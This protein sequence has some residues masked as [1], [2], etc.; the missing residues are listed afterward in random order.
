MDVKSW[1]AKGDEIKK[2]VKERKESIQQAFRRETGL[3]L[4]VVKQGSINTNTVNT[5][6]RFF[7]NPELT[8]RLTGLDV[9]LIR[10]MAIILQCISSGEKINTESF[11]CFAVKQQ[12]YM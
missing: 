6:R 11:G 7:G 10:R 4:D 12:I 8:A 9:K 2:K 1:Q 5:A 3:L